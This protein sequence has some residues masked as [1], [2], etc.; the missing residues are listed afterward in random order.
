MTPNQQ[1]A[2]NQMP[3]PD[4]PDAY[5]DGSFAILR[6]WIVK[7]GTTSIERHVKALEQALEAQRMRADDWMNEEDKEARDATTE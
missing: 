3:K 4:W 2:D 5:G 7:D 6:R 1:R